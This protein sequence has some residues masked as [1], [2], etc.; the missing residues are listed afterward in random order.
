MRVHRQNIVQL[1]GY[2]YEIRHEYVHEN[3]ELYFVRMDHR[4]LCFE[5][6]HGGSL[7]KHLYGMLISEL[8]FIIVATN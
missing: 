7:D 1:L 5:Y 6:L 8:D 4:V 3:G 2:C